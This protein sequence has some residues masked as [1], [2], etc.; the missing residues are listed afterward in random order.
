[1]NSL[2]SPLSKRILLNP[3]FAAIKH[4]P[5]AQIN[6]SKLEPILALRPDKQDLS[7]LM[8]KKLAEICPDIKDSKRRFE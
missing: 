2:L 7:T 6:L 1:M 4:I 5:Y 3:A 8:E